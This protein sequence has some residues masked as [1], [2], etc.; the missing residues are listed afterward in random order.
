[1]DKLFRIETLR[2]TPNPQQ[3]AWLAAHQDY[4]SDY[5]INRLDKAPNETTAGEYV[6]KHLLSGDRGHFGPLEHCQITLACGYINHGTVQQLTRHRLVSFDVQSFRYTGQHVVE[7]AEG[8][9]NPEEVFY[10]RPVGDYASRQGKKYEYTEKWRQKD[11]DACIQASERYATSLSYDMAEENA[12]GMLPFDYRQ[13]F[14]MSCNARSLCH[15]LDMRL[16]KD[17]QIEIQWFSQLLL[18]RFA[19]FVPAIAEWYKANRA[20]KGRLAP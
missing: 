17:S 7:V 9:R 2:A 20:H 18:E 15:L 4:C 1:V 10:L 16:K 5:I 14:V 3:L 19:E 11:L 8:R 13:H 12:R 6:V